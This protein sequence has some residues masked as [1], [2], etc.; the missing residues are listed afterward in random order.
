MSKGTADHDWVDDRDPDAPDAE[1]DDQVP[2][3]AAS[4]DFITVGELLD[5]PEEDVNWIIDGLLVAGGLSLLLAKPKVGKSTL[6][7]AIACAVASG[8]EILGRSVT[9]GPVLYLSLEERGADVRAHFARM[10]ADLPPPLQ[11]VA[12]RRLHVFI[13]PPPTPLSYPTRGGN[14]E[15]IQGHRLEWLERAIKRYRPV[16]VTI[17][18]LGRFLALKDG[19][20][21]HEVTAA[22]GPMIELAHTHGVHLGFTHHAKKD[23]RELIDASL[24]STALAGMV[25]TVLLERRRQDHIRTI[26]SNQRRGIDLDEVILT[27]DE[28]SGR[29]S[30]TGT[31]DCSPS[32]QCGPRR[33]L[34]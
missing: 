23:T 20:D 4:S 11:R 9:P 12:R 27:L 10:I 17:D 6:A 8:T 15:V 7:R 34:S 33:V 32:E 21:Y 18:T 31:V 30:L 2:R 16:L 5:T 29:L 28:A 13:G 22:S 19:N 24:G 26:A 1:A 25:D 14:H 3:R